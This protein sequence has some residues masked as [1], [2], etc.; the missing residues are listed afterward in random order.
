MDEWSRK[1]TECSEPVISRD[2]DDIF[3]EQI[4][5]SE[6]LK[7]RGAYRKC[8]VMDPE[9]DWFLWLGKG[10]SVDV[11]IQAILVA[12][13]QWWSIL[14]LGADVFVN[15][16]RVFHPSPWF[17]W[18]RILYIFFFLIKN[19]F[20]IEIISQLQ[21]ESVYLN[22]NKYSRLD[23]FVEIKFV[24][25]NLLV[26]YIFHIIILFD[27]RRKLRNMYKIRIVKWD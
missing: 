4:V 20:L 6:V 19:I 15:V 27:S 25:N 5:R 12:D 22:F 18:L 26:K 8:T 10:V 3:S 21:F 23:N 2:D 13:N 14:D 11:Q 1:L 24:S 9:H 16:G 7:A 17:R